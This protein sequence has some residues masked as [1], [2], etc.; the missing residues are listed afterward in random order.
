M[1]FLELFALNELDYTVASRGD[2]YHM[3]KLTVAAESIFA[4]LFDAYG[5]ASLRTASDIAT[6]GCNRDEPLAQA[7]HLPRAATYHWYVHRTRRL[8]T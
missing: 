5:S 7:L 3:C 6:V 4:E 8:L 2:L 1:T